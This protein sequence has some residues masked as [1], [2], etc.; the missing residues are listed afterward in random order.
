MNKTKLAMNV[1]LTFLLV[2]IPTSYNMEDKIPL[3]IE[4][5][6]SSQEVIS[7]DKQPMV[8]VDGIKIN[9]GEVVQTLKIEHTPTP[10]NIPEYI[11]NENYETFKLTAYNLSESDCGKSPQRKDFGISASGYDLSKEDITNRK[12]AVDPRVIKLG[13]QVVIEFPPEIRY[14]TLS[15]GSTHD[16]NGTYTAVDTGGAI[17]GNKIDLFVGGISQF[18]QKLS[19]DIGVRQVKVRRIRRNQ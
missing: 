6:L 8:K 16:L 10:T 15:D 3:P 19:L 18:I 17:K 9:V 7:K 2:S 13:E 11:V 5:S 12:I 4:H 1:L 14:V